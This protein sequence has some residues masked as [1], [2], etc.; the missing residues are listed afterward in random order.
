MY[1]LLRKG[2]TGSYQVEG[3]SRVKV[4]EVGDIDIG[5]DLQGNTNANNTGEKSPPRELH[6]ADLETFKPAQSKPNTAEEI[7]K[8]AEEPVEYATIASVKKQ[9]EAKPEEQA[10]EGGD[11]SQTATTLV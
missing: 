11:K 8:P 3:G 9:A 5:L 2:G 6:Y 1:L 10:T 7:P 4:E